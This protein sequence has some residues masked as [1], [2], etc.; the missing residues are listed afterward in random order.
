MFHD[1][2]SGAPVRLQVRLAMLYA[3]RFDGTSDGLRVRQLM[4]LLFLSDR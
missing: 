2:F 4:D 1:V 3:L